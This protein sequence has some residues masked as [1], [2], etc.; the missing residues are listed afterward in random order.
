MLISA[1][2]MIVIFTMLWGFGSES[3]Q[4]KQKRICRQ[5]LQKLYLSMEIYANDNHGDFPFFPAA[6][7]SEQALNVLVPKY[8][9]DTS[10][11]ICP[12]GK[13][14]GI[15]AG[16]PILKRKISYAYYMGRRISDAGEALISDRQINTESKAT[17]DNVFSSTGKAPGNN[18][19][20]YG[21]NFL[22]CDGHLESSPP[23]AAFPLVLTQGVVLLNP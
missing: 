5:N 11:F 9:A 12:G 10:I 22:F 18:H 8:T 16:E 23:R 21:G 15:P 19:H 6:Q 4:A 7:N 17:N 3:N 13:D 1:V 20:K 2:L 14:S